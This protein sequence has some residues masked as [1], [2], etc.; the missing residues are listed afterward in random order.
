MKI[1]VLISRILVGSLFIV[2]GLIKANDPLGFSYKLEDYFAADVLNLEFMV[3][4]ALGL[5]MFICVVE[6]VLGAATLF[7]AKM[8]LVSWSLL[9]MIVFFTFLTFYSAQF[10][11][12]T[13][14]GCFG[15]AL[16]LTPW[17]SFQ[18]DIVLLALVL[19]IFLR[20]KKIELTTSKDEMV[21]LP[22]SLILI[23]V[24]AFGIFDWA[25]IFY[26]TIGLFLMLFIFRS[27]I[28]NHLTEWLMGAVA[29]ILSSY[30]TMYCYNHL[31]I[32]DYR[33]YA[34]GNNIPE[35]RTLPEDAQPD[36]YE[37]ILTYRNLETE[38]V[39]D[40]SQQDY[41]WDDSSWVWVNTDSKLIQ[42]GDYPPIHDFNLFDEDGNDLT[43]GILAE[44]LIFLY[45]SKDINKAS[46]DAQKQVAAFAEEVF[47]AGYYMYGISPSGYEDVQ[48]F[49]HK[50][51][52]GF[53][54]LT[55]DETMLKTVVRANPGLIMLKE[56]T[57]TGKWHYS[58][59]PNFTE[60]NL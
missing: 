55:A 46:E 23:A 12:V 56:G 35:L 49:R 59:F 41:P 19:I 3:P 39:K 54:F 33:P 47:N 15:D 27:Y 42:E 18:K 44:P 32:R 57:I 11:K 6:I 1:A 9:L 10:D 24:M 30:F 14:C 36:V 26:F 13:D 37:T 16:K 43:E 31:P 28:K 48:A 38:E 53:D 34:V 5:A 17:E 20:R 58:D 40:F 25:V 2:S 4:W 60:L 8:K 52:L 22:A 50:H 51:Q 7:G 21:I 29:I 45:I